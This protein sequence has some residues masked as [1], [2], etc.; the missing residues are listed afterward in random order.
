M[1]RKKTILMSVGLLG[2]VLAGLWI[3]RG[4]RP[5]KSIEV[6]LESLRHHDP[7]TVKEKT[8]FLRKKGEQGFKERQYLPMIKAYES[9]VSKY[10]N[11]RD[12]KLRLAKLYLATGQTEKAQ[13]LLEEVTSK[14]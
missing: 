1:G 2:V 9:L 13:K 8:D 10:P 3:Y 4:Y 7:F 14:P 5:K 12:L 11:D 6:P